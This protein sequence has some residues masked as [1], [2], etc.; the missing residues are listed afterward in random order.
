MLELKIDMFR[1][2]WKK[3]LYFVLQVLSLSY[4]LHIMGD[5]SACKIKENAK[6]VTMMN[7]NRGFTIM[8]ATH[9]FIV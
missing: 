5:L 3:I 2:V 9:Q 7:S 8:G 4:S 6:R 1:R